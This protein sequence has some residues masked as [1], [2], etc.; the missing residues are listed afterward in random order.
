MNSNATEVS[1]KFYCISIRH[2][3]LVSIICLYVYVGSLF[4]V[5]MMMAKDMDTLKA[6]ALIFG[7]L[8]A[9]IYHFVLRP[10]FPTAPAAV[11]QALTRQQLPL[12]QRRHSNS[13]TSSSNNN[14]NNNNANT[15]TAARKGAPCARVPSHVAP[16]S[17]AVNGGNNLLVDGMVAFRHGKAAVVESALD[18]AQQA[19]VRKDRARILAR[20]LRQHDGGGQSRTSNSTSASAAAS[21]PPGKGST[22]V[23]AIPQ[24][25]VGC[26]QLRNVLYLLATYYNLLVLVA[27]N[28]DFAPKDKG[29]LIQR[30]RGPTATSVSTQHLQLTADVLPDHRIILS[31]TVAGRVAFSRQLQRIELVLD[32]DSDVKAMLERFGHCVVVYGK[33]VVSRSSKDNTSSSLLGLAVN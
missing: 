25:D 4:V 10:L 3:I 22:V 11:T 31:S 2:Q 15:P 7:V 29:L 32:F 20:L 23:L 28:S 9:L 33:G 21:P 26:A 12:P 8:T 18:A 17:T 13:T 30:L 1:P 16:G 19:R 5:G 24:A 6:T 14:N 27:V